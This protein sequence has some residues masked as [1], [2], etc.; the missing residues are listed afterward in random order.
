MTWLRSDTSSSLK[1]MASIILTGHDPVTVDV[2][3]VQTS[4]HD[5]YQEVANELASWLDRYDRIE[6]RLCGTAYNIIPFLKDSVATLIVDNEVET[7]NRI[8]RLQPTVIIAKQPSLI[9]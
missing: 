8:R 1:G 4:Q 7:P 9:L 2:V 3:A 6:C 5:F